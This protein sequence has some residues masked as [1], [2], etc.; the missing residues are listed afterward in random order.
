MMMMFTIT[1]E[2]R[3]RER[4]GGLSGWCVVGWDVGLARGVGPGGDGAR[5]GARRWPVS[6]RW[7]GAGGQSSDN[8]E[9]CRKLDHRGPDPHR[10][11]ASHRR[12]ETPQGPCK[13]GNSTQ[14]T[15]ARGKPPANQQTRALRSL[16]LYYLPI[17]PPPPLSLLPPPPP[18]AW[19]P[20]GVG[21]PRPAPPRGK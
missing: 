20:A 14:H 7:A 8:M 2:Q 18:G 6:A 13:G 17:S 4:G 15:G 3:E 16:L 11:S 9:P 10:A 1:E 21:R 12:G 5:W 19:P